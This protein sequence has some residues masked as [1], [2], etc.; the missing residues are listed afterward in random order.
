MSGLV[1]LIVRILIGGSILYFIGWVM[2]VV[3]RNLQMQ[4]QILAAQQAPKI[5]LTRLD[6]DQFEPFSFE[7]SE[8][9]IGRD[10]SCTLIID[11]ET[12]SSRH[13]RIV[14]RLNQWWI[15]DLRSTNGTFLNEEPV[16][17]LTVLVSG[18]EIRVGQTTIKIDLE[19]K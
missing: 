18:D 7:K 1:V 11:E 19:A 6:T 14:Y 8:I 5:T 10:P 15:E 16:H 4:T 9:F 13:A 17:A 3:W 12:V 2:L